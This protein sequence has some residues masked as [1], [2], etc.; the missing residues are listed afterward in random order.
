MIVLWYL[1][2]KNKLFFTIGHNNCIFVLNL[3]LN[4]HSNKKKKKKK[5]V[6]PVC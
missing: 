3:N 1:K 5:N 4:W 6:K 2:N